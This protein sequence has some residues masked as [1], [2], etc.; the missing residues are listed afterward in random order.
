MKTAIRGLAAAPVLA[1]LCVSVSLAA[2]APADETYIYSTY[3]YCDASRQDEADALHARVDQPLYAAAV[4]DGTIRSFGWMA[5]HTGGQ[6]RRGEYFAASSIEALLAAQEKLGDAA[7]AKDKKAGETFGS[8]CR[9]H[10]DYIWRRVAGNEIGRTRGT[11]GFSAYYV[12]DT[13]REAQADA[14]VKRV[15]GPIHDKL[16]ADGMLVSWG[17]NEHIVGGEYR[18]LATMTA[19]DFPALMKARAAAVEAMMK[20]PLTDLF[21]DICGSHA[22]YMWE[23]KAQA[24]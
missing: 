16:V 18:R 20:D 1:C 9:Q 17:W 3:H 6:W 22:D 23:I 5:H 8:I 13:S 14:L 7:E 11:A 10:D 12:C 15:I 2:D 24:P 4:A 19:K 21:D